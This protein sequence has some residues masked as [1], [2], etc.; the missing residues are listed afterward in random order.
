M[1]EQSLGHVTHSDNLIRLVTPDH[2]IEATFAP[3]DFDSRPTLGAAS[4]VW[5]LDGPRRT[6]RSARPARAWNTIVGFDALFV[7]TQVA[8]TLMPDVLRRIPSVVS[9]D[10][11]PIQFDALGLYYGHS[12]NGPT[13]RAD[14]VAP[15][16]VVLRP[17]RVA[18]RVVELGEAGTRR[19][20]RG[21]S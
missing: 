6:S 12:T 20:V 8:A 3:I 13:H 14:Q 7:H 10:A 5:L 4:R 11:T 1:L 15:E 17:R 19:S 18:R 9:L 21:T 2:R 16:P